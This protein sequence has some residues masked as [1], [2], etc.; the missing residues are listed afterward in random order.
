MELPATMRKMYLP[1]YL[2]ENKDVF[3]DET[4]APD[5]GR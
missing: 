1:P 4:A 2:D 5:G 3:L